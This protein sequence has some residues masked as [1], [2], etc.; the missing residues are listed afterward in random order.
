[1][2][3]KSTDTESKSGHFDPTVS[4]TEYL[5]DVPNL[6]NWVNVTNLDTN[7]PLRMSYL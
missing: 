1:M 7:R 2:Y 5:N 6:F 3:M 4:W